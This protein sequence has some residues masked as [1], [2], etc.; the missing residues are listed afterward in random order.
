MPIRLERGDITRS[1][2][3]AIVNAANSHLAPG[4]G[5]SGAI[6]RA[7]GRSIAEEGAQWVRE[8][9]TVP[10][11]GAAAT[12]AGNLPSRYVIHAVGPIWQG[13]GAQE[14]ELLASAYRSSIEV[15][16]ELGLTS[17]AF[18][19]ISTGIF[20]YPVEQAAPVAI[21]AVAGALDAARHVCEATFVLYDEETYRAY[22][23]AYE[24]A[25]G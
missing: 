14:T 19:S 18:P 4:G 25:L 12:T 10:V 22:E 13:G 5:V 24:R 7:G 2:A 16:D 3:D 11:G 9:G 21:A 17:I 20:G 1:H 6:H 8:H 23:R 15:A